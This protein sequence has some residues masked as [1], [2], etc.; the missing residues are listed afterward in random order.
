MTRPMKL[1]S[2][3]GLQVVNN[4][5]LKSDL[6]PDISGQPFLGGDTDY[7]FQLQARGLGERDRQE[8]LGG[9][10]GQASLSWHS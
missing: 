10:G 9:P 3:W 2:I 5:L 4:L 7:R 1:H 8:V 6:I